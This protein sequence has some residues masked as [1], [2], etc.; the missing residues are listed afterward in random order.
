MYFHGTS[1]EGLHFSDKNA[2]LMN[3]F[4][5]PDYGYAIEHVKSSFRISYSILDKIAFLLNEYLSLNIKETRVSFRSIWYTD[6]KKKKTW[7]VRMDGHSF[8]MC[9]GLPLQTLNMFEVNP[10]IVEGTD[11]EK[12]LFYRLMRKLIQETNRRTLRFV[13]Y[14]ARCGYTKRDY[15]REF[16]ANKTPYPTYYLGK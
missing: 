5:Y 3:T 12:R 14:Y 8:N 7:R 9:D 6:T 4:D 1:T 10:N 16:V 2:Y 15:L 13:T 11:V